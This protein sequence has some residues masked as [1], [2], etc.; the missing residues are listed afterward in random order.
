MIRYYNGVIDMISTRRND[1][2]DIETFN[3]EQYT[4]GKFLIYTAAYYRLRI[5]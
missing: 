4:K 2:V 3:V 5:S 1:Y